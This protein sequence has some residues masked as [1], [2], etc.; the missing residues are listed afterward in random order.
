MGCTLWC[1][2]GAQGTP[3]CRLLARRQGCTGR[4]PLRLHQ[5]IHA[6]HDVYLHESGGWLVVVYAARLLAARPPRLRVQAYLQ[7]SS[8]LQHIPV[9][10][11]MRCTGCV[12]GAVRTCACGAQLSPA[13]HSRT[14]IPSAP[15]VGCSCY[16]H[17]QQGAAITSRQVVACQ[18]GWLTVV[19]Q[20]HLACVALH[21]QVQE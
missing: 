20:H 9:V 18:G 10:V 3:P 8:H 21:R 12:V 11:A 6:Q 7:R 16:P 2:S 15:N 4:V 13:L 1:L 19:K 17:P 14:D 5:L